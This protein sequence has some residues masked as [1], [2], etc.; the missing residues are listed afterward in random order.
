MHGN[1]GLTL[2]STTSE[3]IFVSLKKVMHDNEYMMCAMCTNNE[4]KGNA[5]KTCKKNLNTTCSC[6]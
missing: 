1:T 5:E 4:E 2:S 3:N 6:D